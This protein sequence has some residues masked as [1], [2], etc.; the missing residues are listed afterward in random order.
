MKK[1]ITIIAGLF[2][3]IQFIRPAKNDSSAPTPLSLKA[4]YGLPDSVEQVLKV[5]CYDCH[6]NHSDYPWYD[7]V[8]PVMWFVTY[9]IHGGKSHLNFDEFAAYPVKKKE[10]RLKG[11]VKT[12][13]L[14]AMPLNSYTWIHRNARLS[15][16][17]KQMVS[18]W[19]A[20]L[21]KQI[22]DTTKAAL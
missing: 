15:A 7:R 17:Q 22:A 9:H 3:L 21:G 12:L 1:A 2:I 4:C 19:A 5:S 18:D 13:Q 10:E 6:S 11:I 20:S 8:Q 14:N 16:A